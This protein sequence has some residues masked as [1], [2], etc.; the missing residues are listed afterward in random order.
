[1][2]ATKGNPI[3]YWQPKAT[4]ATGVG[5]RKATE[6]PE[7]GNFWQPTWVEYGNFWQPMA[8]T[9]EKRTGF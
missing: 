6:Q 2:L 7:N 1:L 9:D 8:T 3:Y 5:T 4:K